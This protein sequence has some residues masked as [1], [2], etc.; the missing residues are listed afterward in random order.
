M[1]NLAR[2]HQITYLSF[3]DPS[4]TDADREGMR[5]VC[6]ELDV[7]L[8][9]DPAKG[10]PRFYLDAARHV[11]DT[12][13]YAVAKYQCGAFKARVRRH[14]AR[15]RFD[16]VVS[17]FLVPVVNLPARLPCPAVLFTHNVEADIWR[18]HAETAGHAVKRALLRQQWHRML[19]FRGVGAPS[20][21]ISSSP[22][23]RTT[24]TPSSAFYPGGLRRPAHVVQ[25]GVDTQFFTPHG[26]EPRIFTWSSPVR[27]TGCPTKMACRGSSATSCRI[28]DTPSRTS[29]RAG[30]AQHAMTKK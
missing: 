16:L 6:A 5:Q 8:R 29:A 18:R 9:R 20:V 30:V 24:A 2:R 22:Y 27:W 15:G 1:R 13:P 11:I 28:S 4:A 25:T 14:L 21:R 26:G 17:D 23:P 10:T 3:V 19:P 12:A 7:V